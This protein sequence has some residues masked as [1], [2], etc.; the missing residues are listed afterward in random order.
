M[1][2]PGLRAAIALGVLAAASVCSPLAIASNA[3]AEPVQ[4]A[5]RQTPDLTANW[6]FHYGDD[7]PGATA[8]AF[9]DS[10]WQAVSLPHTWNRIG[11]YGLARTATNENRQSVGYYRLTFR[12]P[13]CDASRRH[14]LR[15]RS[16]GAARSG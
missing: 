11:Q 7:V 15:I 13:S 4:S 3:L 10:A 16:H 5:P 12:G 8:A 14:Y 6:R 1:G 2:K 9:D